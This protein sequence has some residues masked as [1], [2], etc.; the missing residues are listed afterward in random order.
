[1]EA[2][3]VATQRKEIEKMSVKV[4]IWIHKAYLPKRKILVQSFHEKVLLTTHHFAAVFSIKYFPRAYKWVKSLVWFF[5]FLIKKRE[6]EVPTKK[7]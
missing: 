3:V 7:L 6:S 1:M 5:I 2:G 4:T